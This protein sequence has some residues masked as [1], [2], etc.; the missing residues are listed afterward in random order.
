[1]F[2]AI[3]RGAPFDENNFF[4]IPPID[5]GEIN[6]ASYVA[7][8]ISDIEGGAIAAPPASYFDGG[9]I[10]LKGTASYDPNVTYGPDSPIIGD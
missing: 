4:N 2:M 10:P 1:M 3:R 8:K 7:V 9:A 5:G 6:Q